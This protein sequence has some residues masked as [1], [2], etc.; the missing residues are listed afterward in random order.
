MRCVADSGDEGMRGRECC[1]GKENVFV[2]L[3]RFHDPVPDSS[4]HWNLCV[5][6]FL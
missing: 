6:L 2:V 1:R 3:S 4:V 5:G